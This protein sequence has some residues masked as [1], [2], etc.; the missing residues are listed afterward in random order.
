MRMTVLLTRMEAAREVIEAALE[1]SR[2]L[3]AGVTL[4][5]VREERLFELPIFGE[6]EPSLEGAREHLESLV[7]EAGGEEWAVLAYEDDPV[8]HLLLEADREKAALMMSDLE[9]GERA[10]LIAKARTPLLLLKSGAP[11]RYEHGLIV[12][13]PAY[14]EAVC[15]PAVYRILDARRWSAYMDYQVVP[16]MGTDLSLDPVVDTLATD[17]QLEAEVMDARKKAFLDLCEREEL[18]GVF[19]VGEHGMVEDILAQAEK[20]GAD[21]LAVIA[22]DHETLLAEALGELAKRVSHDLLI[23]FQQD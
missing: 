21:C 12:F 10:E 18:E 1:R 8:D 19:E 20:V 5:Y 7:R 11:H 6:E 15:L 13:D 4:L 9:G 16:T 2:R 14:S 3:G 17:I 23:C 22:E